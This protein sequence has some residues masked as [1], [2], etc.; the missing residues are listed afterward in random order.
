MNCNDKSHKHIRHCY[1]SF[2]RLE[3][4]RTDITILDISQEDLLKTSCEFVLFKKLL[5]RL[6]RGKAEDWLMFK[7]IFE[8]NISELLT[9]INSRW[10]LS[11]I[12]TYA[13]CGNDLE[14]GNALAV[15]NIFT[16]EKI[17]ATDQIIFNKTLKSNQRRMD[18]LPLW[19]GLLT[20][21]LNLDDMPRNFLLRN[22]KIL[23]RTPV[24]KKV[25]IELFKRAY[26][27]QNFSMNVIFNNSTFLRDDYNRLIKDKMI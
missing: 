13:D 11:I 1:N 4:D 9:V 21:R 24:L 18:Q 3:Y 16:L 17:Y 2:L 25:F 20:L 14:S 22:L 7:S 12:D 19:D 26:K 8:K 6:R 23:T 15:S 5:I 27:N 10:L